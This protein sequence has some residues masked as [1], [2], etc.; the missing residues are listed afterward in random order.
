M[1]LAL[2]AAC[3]E[4]VLVGLEV[5]L[6]S[7]AL[8][9]GAAFVAVPAITAPTL[10]LGFAISRCST[11]SLTSGTVAAATCYTA[12]TL[13]AYLGGKVYH[14]AVR[15][16]DARTVGLALPTCHTGCACVTTTV[17]E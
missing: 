12:A 16:L 11:A 6:A 7:L 8:V 15:A 2:L 1:L 17:S 10:L 14:T 13:L 3:A 5:H 4:L 9:A